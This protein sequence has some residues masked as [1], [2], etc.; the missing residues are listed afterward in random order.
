MNP[1]LYRCRHEWI[2]LTKYWNW[3]EK[4][5]SLERSGLTYKDNKTPKNVMRLAEMRAGLLNLLQGES[6]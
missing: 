4:C 2:G 6:K 3:C 1:E 5:G